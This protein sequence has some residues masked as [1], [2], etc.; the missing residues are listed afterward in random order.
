MDFNYLQEIE[1]TMSG[2]NEELYQL[3]EEY[4]KHF[5]RYPNMPQLSSETVEDY[6]TALKRC[7]QDK[8]L[9]EDLNPSLSK[10]DANSED[11]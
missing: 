5:G 10:N 7:L 2:F 9:L 3:E 1:A 11:K 8:I 6:I 4:L